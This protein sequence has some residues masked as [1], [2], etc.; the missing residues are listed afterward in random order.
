[1]SNAYA[2]AA[3]AASSPW[4]AGP[5]WDLFWLSLSATLVAVPPLAHTY[6]HVGA[7]GVDLLVTAM[8]GGPH[9]YATLLRTVLEPRFRDRHPLLTWLPVI[10]VPTG[11]ALAAAFAFNA[12]LSLFFMWASIHICDQASYIAS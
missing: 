4:I 6:W 10:A 7:D 2:P 9:M 8:I 1:M 3:A 12:L 5:R 11:V